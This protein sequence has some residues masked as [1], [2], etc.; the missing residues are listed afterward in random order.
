MLAGRG[1]FSSVMT[2]VV[3]VWGTID[4]IALLVM[5]EFGGMKFERED[6]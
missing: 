4:G 6:L 1:W 2:I 5:I 3:M